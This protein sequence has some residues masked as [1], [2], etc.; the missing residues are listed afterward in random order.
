ME[1]LTIERVLGRFVPL[2]SAT[3]DELRPIARRSLSKRVHKHYRGFAQNQLRFLE[4]E[5][6]TKKLLYVLRTT[7]TGIRL[8]ETGELEPDVTELVDRYGLPEAAALVERKRVGERVGVDPKLLEAWRPRMDELF[9]RL[10]AAHH[11]SPLPESPL[12]EAEVR[13]WLLA[14]RRAR[15]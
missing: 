11:K 2:A 9:L 8:L 15:M 14:V 3:L 4:K 1:R 6:T 5:P 7:L 13:D 12:N 10:D